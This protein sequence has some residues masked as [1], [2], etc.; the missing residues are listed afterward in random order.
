MHQKQNCKHWLISLQ[1]CRGHFP[2]QQIAEPYT[3]T[4]SR[5]FYDGKQHIYHDINIYSDLS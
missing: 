2:Y 4:K 5:S 1:T 3:Q